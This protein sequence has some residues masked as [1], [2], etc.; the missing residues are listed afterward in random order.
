MTDIMKKINRNKASDIYKIKPT[1]MRDLT[2]FIAPILT[3]HTNKAI[4]E[5]DYP[6]P[7][8]LTKVIELY[9]AKQ[10]D[11]PAN[12]R[13]I[14]LLPI[15]AKLIDTLINNQ[16][17]EHLTEHNI[18]SPTQY[19]FRP[20]SSTTLAL[21]TILDNI[22]KH[23][24][25]KHP[26]LAIYIDLSK[27]YDTISHEK[28]LHKLRHDFNFTTE[29][30]TFFKSYFRNRIQTMHTQHAQSEERVITD[31][32]PQGSTLSTTFFLL[33]IN[34]IIRTVPNS[35]V[36]TYADDTT[37]IVT[38]PSIPALQALAQT[39]LNSLINYFHTN[40]L[41][42][43]PTKTNYSVFCPSNVIEP[44]VQWWDN[45]RPHPVLKLQVQTT[46]LRQ[47]RQAKLLGVMIQDNLKFHQ[48]V[49]KIIKKLQPTIQCFRYANK[50]LPTET[51][52]QLY[53]SQIFPHLIGEIT[54]WGTDNPYTSYLQPL[55]RT[56]KRIIRLIKNLPPRTHTKPLMTELK[57]LNISNLYIHRTCMQQHSFVY[58]SRQLNRPQHN[59]QPLWTAEVHDY[60]T[61]YSLQRH[62]YVPNP[63]KQF[64]KRR[65]AHETSHFAAKHWTIW[66]SMPE[67][68]RTERNRE[69]FKHAL[70]E[71]LLQRQS[72]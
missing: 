9:K 56:H 47:K 43:N 45:P 6:D 72:S 30:V 65:P 23:K 21:Q 33:Y 64:K 27:A 35:S 70:K 58:P 59:N 40:D 31:G 38:S 60:P 14:S 24:S 67:L 8:K 18:I 46:R 48:T 19:A 16:L 55:V 53:Y 29:T 41:V 10:R 11:N 44:S 49:L 15:I 13:P 37:L 34:D 68:I 36:Y 4:D 71:H 20:N 3:K 51:M 26:T 5:H 17:M 52:R 7:L 63:H 61:R 66:N 57:I 54:V 22:H 2:D 12:Y 32:I 28:L 1:I 42:P 50:L 25:D 62:Q 39:E 69:A